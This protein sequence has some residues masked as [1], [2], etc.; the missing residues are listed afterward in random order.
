MRCHTCLGTPW[1]RSKGTEAPSRTRRVNNV[2]NQRMW[3]VG[4]V[5]T[6]RLRELQQVQ[7]LVACRRAL[8]TERGGVWGSFALFESVTVVLLNTEFWVEKQRCWA[9]TCRWLGGITIIRNVNY[10]SNEA[11]SQPGRNSLSEKEPKN[12]IQPFSTMATGWTFWGSNPGRVK[13]FFFSPKLPDHPWGP[14]A[15]Y[16]TSTGGSFWS[17]QGTYLTTHLHVVP[18]LGMSGA[19]HPLV[20]TSP[21]MYWRLN[22]VYW[23]SVIPTLKSNPLCCRS[24]VLCVLAW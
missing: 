6:L 5:F 1:F 15:S 2:C 16:S 7:L 24:W 20:T 8:V 17:G 18:R 21:F 4:H 9:N 14:P 3:N 12:F 22:T 11:E 19:V 13:S 23:F 10:S